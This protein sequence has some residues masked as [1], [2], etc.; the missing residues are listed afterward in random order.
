[1]K[2]K[3]DVRNE[4]I[5]YIHLIWGTKKLDKLDPLIQLMI[6][7]T[8]NEVYLLN[9]NINSFRELTLNRLINTFSSTNYIRPSHAILQLNP[10]GPSFHLKKEMK[11][12]LKKIPENL[13]KYRF[14][15][16][17]YTPVIDSIIY[18]IE[19]CQSIHDD[20]NTISLKIKSS[21]ELQQRKNLTFYLDFPHLEEN[22]VYYDVLSEINWIIGG[23]TLKAQ[24][25][26][27]IVFEG[28]RVSELEQDILD[29]Y[30]D[31]FQTIELET[32]LSEISINFPPIFQ[33]KDLEKL[34]ISANAFPVVNRYYHEPT[35]SK[36]T[37]TKFFS[38]V[39]TPENYFLESASPNSESAIYSIEPRH[40]RF[41]D[42][43]NLIEKMEQLLDL[44]QHEKKAFPGI[45][46]EKITEISNAL[47]TIQDSDLSKINH[48]RI[49]R[50]H[51]LAWVNID[52][53]K[54][55]STIKVPFWS[56]NG[57]F[58][59][60]ISKESNIVSYKIP[61]LKKHNPKFLTNPTNGRNFNQQEDFKAISKFQLCSQNQIRTKNDI[62]NFCYLE[63]KNRAENIEIIHKTEISP[64]QKEGL[65]NL[66]EIKI[67]PSAKFPNYFSD[68][69][70]VRDFI[71]QLKKKSPDS[72]NYRVRITL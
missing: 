20:S 48:N 25:G 31:R 45:D 46:P 44:I 13:Q 50:E 23:K 69:K 58:I 19:I 5:H 36:Q 22:H 72:Y 4:L 28:N 66:I 64:K 47:V 40:K 6:E 39:S 56:T 49:N 14:Q 16:I 61:E 38:L 63:L 54:D 7:A 55:V 71:C 70:T 34:Q 17:E 3:D 52:F 15:S 57:N 35:F 32:N 8:I 11:F 1:M 27:P 24:S 37:P 51:E 59:Q 29:F 53:P 43:S 33:R 10:D 9:D 68:K 60:D 41:E 12:C 65:I 2:S 30:A 21:K 67:Q 42:E 62:L 18:D 26:F